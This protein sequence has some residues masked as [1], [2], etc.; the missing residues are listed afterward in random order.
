MRSI[1]A[2]QVNNNFMTEDVLFFKCKGECL[3]CIFLYSTKYRDEFQP[4]I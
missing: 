2:L 3:R 1:I 4:L